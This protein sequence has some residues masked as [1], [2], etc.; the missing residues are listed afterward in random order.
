MKEWVPTHSYCC[1]MQ[2][3]RMG[4]QCID[5]PRGCPTIQL[6]PGLQKHKALVIPGLKKYIISILMAKALW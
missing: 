2:N 3:E 6:E 4:L 1:S 5:K